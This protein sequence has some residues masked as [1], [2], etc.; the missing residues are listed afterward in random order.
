MDQIEREVRNADAIKN[1]GAV[2]E[3][4]TNTLR[5]LDDLVGEVDRRAAGCIALAETSAS[6]DAASAGSAGG[7]SKRSHF[8]VLR[9]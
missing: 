7:G 6:G 5:D 3:S 1:G 2:R 9:N 8:F 4:L